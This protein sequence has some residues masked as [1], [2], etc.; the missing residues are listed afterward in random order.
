[1]KLA[2]FSTGTD[3]RLGLV[4]GSSLTDLSARVNGLPDNDHGADRGVGDDQCSDHCCVAGKR[5]IAELS[6][7]TSRRPPSSGRG[8][9]VSTMPITSA[10]PA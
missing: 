6:D 5:L 7:V 9:L 4:H 8:G 3:P 1:M 2:R 10:K